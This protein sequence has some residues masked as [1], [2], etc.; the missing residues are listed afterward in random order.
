MLDEQKAGL[1]FYNQAVIIFS[2][3]LTAW[4]TQNNQDFFSKFILTH[5]MFHSTGHITAFSSLEESGLVKKANQDPKNKQ[6]SMTHL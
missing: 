2:Q 1:I 5:N 6:F 4:H 3:N